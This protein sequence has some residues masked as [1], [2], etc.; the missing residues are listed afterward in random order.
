M[1]MAVKKKVKSNFIIFNMDNL[2]LKVNFKLKFI[3]IRVVIPIKTDNGPLKINLKFLSI[4]S[5]FIFIILIIVFKLFK[6]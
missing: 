6:Y 1:D 2:R 3:K 4:I 5:S